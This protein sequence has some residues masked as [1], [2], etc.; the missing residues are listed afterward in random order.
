MPSAEKLE[1]W[2]VKRQYWH[3]VAIAGQLENRDM[4]DAWDRFHKFDRKLYRYEQ[5]RWNKEWKKAV[6][7]FAPYGAFAS[8]PEI[9][10][11][12]VKRCAEY[13]G[14]G[15]NVWVV[16][17]EVKPIREAVLHAKSLVDKLETCD[18]FGGLPM[19]SH[20]GSY[21]DYMANVKDAHKEYLAILVELFNFVGAH[22]DDWCD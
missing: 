11:T 14:N 6:K 21:E 19:A 16:E 20:H 13:W 3:D 1:K 17:D 10:C 5:K 4:S 8:I 22:C 15:Y 7:D 12:M 2:K 9:L 18:Y